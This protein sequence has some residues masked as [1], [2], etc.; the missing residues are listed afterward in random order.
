VLPDDITQAVLARKDVARYLRGGHGQSE[1]EA[2]ERIEAYLDELRTTQRYPIYRALKHPLYPILRKVER[3]Q[4]HVE[5]PQEAA[6]TGRVI[7][8]SNHKSH[9]DYLVEPLV[10]DDAG[11]R[12]PVTAAG[13]NL[14][15]G[16]LGLLHRHVTG[17][18]PI[19]RNTKDPAYLVTLKAYVA[20]LLQRSDLLF[21]IE[22]GRSYTGELKAAKTGLLHA[23]LQA[24]VEH[25]V[26][27]PVAVA[28]DLVLEDHILPHAAT[29]RRSKPFAREVAEMVRYAVGYQTRAFVTFGQA[30]PLA[31]YDP[32]SRRDVMTLGHQ[33]R[34]TIGTLYKALPTAIVAA[35][36]RP[37]ASRRDLESRA[38]AIIEALAH[39]NANLAVRSGRDAVDAGA[40]LLEARNI[41]HVERGGRFRVRERTVLRYYA[42]TIQHL[43]VPR[44]ARTH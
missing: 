23:A 18:I 35:A 19:R 33:I 37:A 27:V 22:G 38:D 15:G 16:P 11:I 28:Y 3:I 29:K 1:G 42:R 7:Y 39:A 43:L 14:F 17:A 26:V 24:E 6:R 25:A 2:R 31:G 44:R 20:E 40:P 8:V 5:I 9:L 13:I 21:Y 34:D 12:P 41:I 30:I 10:I 4:E 36:M 32:E